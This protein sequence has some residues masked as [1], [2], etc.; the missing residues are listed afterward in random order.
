[1]LQSII[2]H[3]LETVT[4]KPDGT[5]IKKSTH[6]WLA[7]I[8]IISITTILVIYIDNGKGMI[9]KSLGK[10]CLRCSQ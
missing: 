9:S 1:M 8:S 2:G 10:V 6:P 7:P 4:T 3:D 5:I